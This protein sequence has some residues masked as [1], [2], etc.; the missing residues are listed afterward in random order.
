LDKDFKSKLQ[1]YIE[2]KVN[3]QQNYPQNTNYTILPAS[4][5]ATIILIAGILGFVGFPTIGSIVAI[6]TGY[7]AR[8]NTRSIAPKVSGD[9]MTTAGIAME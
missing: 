1:G 9:G 5:L 7:T 6:W 4:T 2:E 3:E 8:R